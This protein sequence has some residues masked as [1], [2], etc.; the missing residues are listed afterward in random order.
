MVVC[1]MITGKQ[2]H[3]VMDKWSGKVQSKGDSR[4]PS[5]GSSATIV[6]SENTYDP[7]GTSHIQSMKIH[8]VLSFSFGELFLLLNNLAYL[9]NLAQNQIL[10]GGIYPFGNGF[11][12]LVSLSPEYIVRL[13]LLPYL[14]P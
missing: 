12:A 7:I 2:L 9:G 11:P 13:H 3:L 6:T 1:L 5:K 4:D 8:V 10:G 14:S